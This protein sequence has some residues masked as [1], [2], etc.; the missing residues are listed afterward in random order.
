MPAFGSPYMPTPEPCEQWTPGL[1]YAPS[2]V[3]SPSSSV[4][5]TDDYVTGYIPTSMPTSMVEAGADMSQTSVPCLD[6]KSRKQ[7]PLCLPARTLLVGR[8]EALIMPS[9]ADPDYAQRGGVR[10]GSCMP[11]QQSWMLYPAYYPQ[12]PAI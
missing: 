10:Q 6:N 9:P 12:S 8:D 2:V 1:N 7:I 5:N 4:G 11:A 3:S